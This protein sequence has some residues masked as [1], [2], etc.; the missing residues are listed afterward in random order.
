[1]AKL[2]VARPKANRKVIINLKMAKQNLILKAFKEIG[3]KNKIQ[4]KAT[5]RSLESRKRANNV[6]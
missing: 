1:M 4:I 2:K 5:I 3:L 6:E